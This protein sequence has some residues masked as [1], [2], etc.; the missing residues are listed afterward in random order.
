M[1]SENLLVMATSMCYSGSLVQEPDDF[2][3]ENECVCWCVRRCMYCT[4]GIHMQ[5]H[6]AVV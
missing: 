3:S 5:N 1:K 2:I 6:V 4:V